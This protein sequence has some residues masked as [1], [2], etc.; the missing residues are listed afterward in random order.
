[1][2]LSR[3]RVIRLIRFVFRFIFWDR[4]LV[5]SMLKIRVLYFVFFYSD[6][7]LCVFLSVLE[8]GG[9][10]GIGLL[11]F[12][13]FGLVVKWKVNYVFKEKF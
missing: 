5:D 2:L 12:I 13:F 8:L 9:W 11:F 1:M 3:D 4:E 6:C 10:K 7:F